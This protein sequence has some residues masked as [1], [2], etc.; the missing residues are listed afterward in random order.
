MISLIQS[1]LEKNGISL[2]HL[3]LSSLERS[4][5][6]FQEWNEKIN[7][8]AFKNFEEILYKHIIDSLLLTKHFTLSGKIL[9]IGTGGGFPLLALKEAFFQEMFFGMDSVQKKLIAIENIHPFFQRNNTLI[10]SRFEDAG[11]NTKYRE[12]FDFVVARAVAPF[13][14]LLEYA[15]P[16]VKPQGM[17]VFY[18]GEKIPAIKESWKQILS[19]TIKNVFSDILFLKNSQEKRHFLIIQKTHFLS[20]EFPRKAPLPKTHPLF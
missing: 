20:K 2:P 19:F 4:I 10:H 6:H 11:Q 9:D 5:I 14:T 12:Q 16:F 7:L 18:L 1:A 8:S 15:L 17:C 3:S 13:P